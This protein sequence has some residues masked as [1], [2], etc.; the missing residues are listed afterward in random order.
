MQTTTNL[1]RSAKLVIKDLRTV[2]K[3]KVKSHPDGVMMLL[4]VKQGTPMA[5]LKMVRDRKRLTIKARLLV[6]KARY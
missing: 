6:E 2:V 4:M 5:R 3:G 1:K